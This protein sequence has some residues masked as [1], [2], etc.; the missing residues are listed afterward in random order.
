MKIKNK[1]TVM[2]VEEE[3]G[4]RGT[5]ERGKSRNMCKG[6]MGM[7]DRVGIDCGSGGAWWVA[8]NRGKQWGN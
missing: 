3:G 4:Y 8:D 1:L 6:P 5:K 2:R 7:D